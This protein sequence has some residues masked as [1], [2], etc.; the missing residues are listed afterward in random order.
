VVPN[1]TCGKRRW[2][3]RLADL[4]WKVSTGDQ[5]K[6]SQ[7]GIRSL[8]FIYIYTYLFCVFEPAWIL[9]VDNA[10]PWSLLLLNLWYQKPDQGKFVDVFPPLS[11]WLASF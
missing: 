8:L 10:T 5:G 11:D 3:R 1:A 7:Y 4:I 2:W 6:K 9:S